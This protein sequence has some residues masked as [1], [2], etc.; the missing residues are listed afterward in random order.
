[1]GKYVAQRG[2]RVLVAADTPQ[3]VVTW[4]RE[5]GETSSVFGLPLDPVA[6]TQL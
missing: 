3:E 6:E 1:M 5:H 4:L 2:E